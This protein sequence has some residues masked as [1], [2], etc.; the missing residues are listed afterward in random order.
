MISKWWINEFSLELFMS[1]RAWTII[2]GAEKF[3]IPNPPYLL[4]APPV[5]TKIDW[6]TS[7]LKFSI[8]IAVQCPNLNF[9]KGQLI[10]EAIFHGLPP[11]TSE[12][13]HTPKRQHFFLQISAPASKMD[14]IRKKTCTL[15]YWNFVANHLFKG[16]GKIQNKILLMW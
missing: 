3:H 7:W 2:W 8:F 15:L 11:R 1:I 10:S 4:L 14:Q 12:V 5:A 16:L 9:A 13:Y 6:H